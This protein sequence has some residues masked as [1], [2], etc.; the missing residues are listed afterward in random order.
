MLHRQGRP[1]ATEDFLTAVAD[2][3]PTLTEQALTEFE[4]DIARYTRM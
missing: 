3:R 4:E 2:T 1:P